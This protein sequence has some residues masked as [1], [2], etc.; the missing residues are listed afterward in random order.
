MKVP[1]LLGCVAVCLSCASP[2]TPES[3]SRKHLTQLTEERAGL[4]WHLNAQARAYGGDAALSATYR[5]DARRFA[6]R[7]A[8]AVVVVTLLRRYGGGFFNAEEISLLMSLG[9]AA[10]RLRTLATGPWLAG[11]VARALERAAAPDSG[12]E[13]DLLE[14]FDVWR[15]DL[16][17]PERRHASVSVEDPGGWSVAVERHWLVTYVYALQT[18]IYLHLSNEQAGLQDFFSELL[19]RVHLRCCSADSPTSFLLPIGW[20]NTPFRKICDYAQLLMRPSGLA[21]I[22]RL[23][24]ASM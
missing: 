24:T 4:A 20:D 12:T 10:Q 21:S 23:T 19:R 15:L 1:G 7:S 5:R 13:A 8:E 14:V 16:S 2:A 3:G 6:L 18:V 11:L 17:L 22:E 9:P